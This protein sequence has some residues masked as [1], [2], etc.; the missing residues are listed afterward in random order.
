MILPQHQVFDL[1]HWNLPMPKIR[2]HMDSV[3]QKIAKAI[4]TKMQF[5]YPTVKPSNCKYW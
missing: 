5:Q 1:P 2:K 4:R 3:L